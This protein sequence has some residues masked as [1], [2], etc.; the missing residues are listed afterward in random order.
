MTGRCL[1][2]LLAAAV[3]LGACNGPTVRLPVRDIDRTPD[4]ASEDGPDAAG[5]GDDDDDQTDESDDDASCDAQNP[6]R[7]DKHKICG[8][9]GLC[10]ECVI[11]A[12][13]E[14]DRTCDEKGDCDSV[15]D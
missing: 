10:V 4:A 12:D 13:C 14:R 9:L 6:C 11:D 15:D 7:D 8:P 3:L 5:R 1:L 2:G